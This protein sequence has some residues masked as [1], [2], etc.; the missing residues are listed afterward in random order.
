MAKTWLWPGE[1]AR[2]LGICAKTVN[3]WADAGAVEVIRDAKG[4]RHFKPEAVQI[5]A[6]RLGLALL[7]SNSE[8]GASNAGA[9]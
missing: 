2:A 6:A 1:V 3:R 4:R 8:E 7:P 9:Q 5:L